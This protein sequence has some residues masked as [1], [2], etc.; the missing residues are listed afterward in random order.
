MVTVFKV[1]VLHFKNQYEFYTGCGSSKSFYR[2]THIQKLGKHFP[3][4]CSM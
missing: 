3:E 2:Y 4:L 1:T